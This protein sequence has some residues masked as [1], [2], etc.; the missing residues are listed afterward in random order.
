MHYWMPQRRSADDDDK[1][2]REHAEGT[3][4]VNGQ[5]NDADLI[6]DVVCSI[7]ATGGECECAAV[8]SLG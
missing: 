5:S 8:E 3:T 6:D 7:E 4:Q 1:D 2:N